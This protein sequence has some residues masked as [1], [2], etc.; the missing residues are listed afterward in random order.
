MN[1]YDSCCK[2]RIHSSRMSTARSLNVSHSICLGGHAW[3]TC[4]PPCTPPSHA[5]P[6]ATHA[7]CHTHPLPRMPPLPCKPT[8][9]DRQTPVKHNLRKLRMRAVIIQDELSGREVEFARQTE[10][11]GI[12]QNDHQIYTLVC[13]QQY[14]LLCNRPTFCFVYVKRNDLTR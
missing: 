3:H 11:T 8:P 4:P 12:S 13:L 7:P 14:L 6:S 2:T 10:Q 1:K 9:V 5:H